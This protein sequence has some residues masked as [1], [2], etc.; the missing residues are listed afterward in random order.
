[1]TTVGDLIS[2]A[3][4]D[5]GIIGIGQTP[6]FEDSNDAFTRLNYMVAQWNR[7]R[8]FIYDLVTLSIV[9]TGAKTYTLGPSGD[10]NVFTRPDKIESA[11]FTQLNTGNLPVDYPLAII[12]AREDYNNITLKTLT[13]FP[14]Y[15]FY[16]T[17]WPLGVLYP[18]PII[19]S[20]LYQL[21]ISIKNQLNQFTS[22]AQVINLPPEYAGA[23]HYNLCTRLRPAYQMAPD[24][25]IIGLAK[26]SLNV[27]RNANAQI[28]LLNMPK[29][30]IRR[31]I[32]NIYSDMNY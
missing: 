13:T 9:S 28:P 3:L 23:L 16:D 29:E 12:D 10:I 11:Y 21:N 18:W 24:P 25:Q 26:D 6:S 19:Q 4:K 30:L 7:K 27:L 17:G 15:L 8:W 5:S 20:G 32:Y 14:E 1:M 2:L 31:G 22:L